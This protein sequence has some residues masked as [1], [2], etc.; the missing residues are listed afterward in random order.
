M[1]RMFTINGRRMTTWNVFVGCLFNCIYCHAREEALTRLRHI[2]RYRDGFKPHLVWSEMN[3]RFRPGDFVFICYMGD[4]SWAARHELELIWRYIALF[5]ETRFLFIS[6]APMVF[7]Q[8]L[9]W[10]FEPTA[11]IYFGTTI[12]SN[13]D[14]GVTTAPAPELRYRAMVELQHPHKFISIEPLMNFHL[15][16]L[17]NWI[18]EIGPEIVEIGPDNYGNNLPEPASLISGAMNAWKV[19]TLLE[20]LR[21]FV[22]M[23]V[24]K[25]GLSR[26]LDNAAA[27]RSS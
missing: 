11:N 18:K 16:T 3:R 12:E 21:E 14:H 22:P 24:E 5:P 20:M 1:T 10:G 6:K 13:I 23:L 27:P 9:E 26:L 15:C 19:R 17:V 25:P 8:W 7:L 4:I 2:A